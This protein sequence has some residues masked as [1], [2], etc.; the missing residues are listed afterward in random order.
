MLRAYG[1]VISA[2]NLHGRGFDLCMAFLEAE[3]F[4]CEPN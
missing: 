1:G 2:T 3:G 4:E